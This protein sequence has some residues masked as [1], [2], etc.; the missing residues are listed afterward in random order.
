MSEKQK[1]VRGRRPE[2]SKVK[3]KVHKMYENFGIDPEAMDDDDLEVV[4]KHYYN[5]PRDL[6]TDLQKSKQH[7]G[8][9]EDDDII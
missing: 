7:S 6:E 1:A 9:F 5:K 8:K 2:M 4:Y 3:S